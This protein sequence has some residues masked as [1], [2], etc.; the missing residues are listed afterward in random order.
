VR[1]IYKDY[2]LDFHKDARKAAEASHCAGEQG[3]YWEYHDVLFTKTNALDIASLKKYADDLKL[4]ANQF[5]ACLDSG[6]YA[7]AISKD[8]AEGAQAGV[9]GTPAFFINGQF[10]SGAQPFAAF[11]DAVEEALE[12]Q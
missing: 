2:P 1:L 11:Q 12:A 10:L 4:D 6:K 5:T 3:K 9:T 7:A 8:M